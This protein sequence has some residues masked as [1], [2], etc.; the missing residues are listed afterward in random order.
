MRRRD[1]LRV[2]G[3]AEEAGV[4]IENDR[5]RNRRPR[6]SAIGSFARKASRKSPDFSAGRIFGAMPPPTYTPAVATAR[7]AMLPDSAP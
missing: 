6:R 2:D 1:L 3:G 7:S 4:R 5:N